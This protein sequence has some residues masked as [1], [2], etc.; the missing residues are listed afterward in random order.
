M[1]CRDFVHTLLHIVFTKV[2]LPQSSYRCDLLSGEGF[3]DDQQL[4]AARAAATGLAS[5]SDAVVHALP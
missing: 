4:H 3:R 5:G 1:E 2:A